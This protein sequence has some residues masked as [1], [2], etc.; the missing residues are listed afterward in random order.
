MQTMPGQPL[1]IYLFRYTV[2]AC[3]SLKDVH[4]GVRTMEAP[5]AI[6]ARCDHRDKKYLQAQQAGSKAATYNAHY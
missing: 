1:N 6:V 4:R 3:Q 5:H 2:G